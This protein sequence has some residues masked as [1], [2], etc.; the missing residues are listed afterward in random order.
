MGVKTRDDGTGR[1]TAM[2]LF[3]FVRLTWHSQG[4][5]V[6]SSS[7]RRASAARSSITFAKA[8]GKK[9]QNPSYTKPPNTR[10]KKQDASKKQKDTGLLIYHTDSFC[11]LILTNFPKEV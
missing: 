5:S 8:S 10:N 3:P 2:T 9:P 1:R 6:Q 7:S 4:Q 11:I